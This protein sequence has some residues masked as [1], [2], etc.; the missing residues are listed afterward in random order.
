MDPD[1]SCL[2]GG[3][4]VYILGQEATWSWSTQQSLVSFRASMLI[5]V[6]A[7]SEMV[8]EGLCT[9]QDLELEGP[10]LGNPAPLLE[11]G[12]NSSRVSG[13]SL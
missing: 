10:L 1:A 11:M 4:A 12:G 5:Q 8:C 6:H 3:V 13:G 2:G 9:P 7:A